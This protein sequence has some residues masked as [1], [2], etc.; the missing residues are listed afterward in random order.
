MTH[1]AIDEA[2]A[3]SQRAPHGWVWRFRLSA[4]PRR[5]GRWLR[6]EV[7]VAGP[8]REAAQL[9]KY[10]CVWRGGARPIVIGVRRVRPAGP[11]R[12]QNPVHDLR[13]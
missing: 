12:E 5:G 1:A 13:F 3:S 9:A 11:G 6:S 7:D 8:Y 2:P 10:V 4:L